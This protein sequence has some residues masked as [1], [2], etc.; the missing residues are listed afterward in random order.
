MDDLLKTI[1]TAPVKAKFD[2]A[3]AGV[4]YYTVSTD[5]ADYTFSID[6]N[7][8]DDVGAANFFAEYK[9]IT[10][11]RYI[12]K[13]IG[14]NTLQIVRRQK[15]PSTKTFKVNGAQWGR[16]E[17]YYDDVVFKAEDEDDLRAQMRK[18]RKDF[19]DLELLDGD[20]TIEEC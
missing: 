17:A 9:P 14:N 15:N 8:T 19:A 3:R 12:R 13:A 7:N 16:W 1:V 10:L 18:V 4:L 2:F 11:T 5:D 20:L 6:M